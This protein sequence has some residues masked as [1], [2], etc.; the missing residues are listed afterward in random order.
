MA[1][2]L[3]PGRM[4]YNSQF[5]I[6]NNLF[7]NKNW[8]KKKKKKKKTP[9]KK[10]KKKKPRKNQLSSHTIVL[11]KGTFLPKKLSFCKKC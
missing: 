1:D 7:S 6:N 8:K 9:K 5:S 3:E 2:L 10:K 4:V 11:S